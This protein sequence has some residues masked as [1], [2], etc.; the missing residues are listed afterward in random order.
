MEKW[1]KCLNVG[2]TSLLAAGLLLTGCG[3]AGGETDANAKSSAGSVGNEGSSNK[4]LPVIQVVIPNGANVDN[5]PAIQEEVN[6]ILADKTGVQINITWLGWGSYMNQTN[7]MLTGEGEADLIMLSGYSIASLAD[8]GQLYDFTDLYES[9]SEVFTK[10]VDPIYIDSGRVDGRLYTIPCNNNFSGEACVIVNRKMADELGFDLTDEEKIWTFEE[11][12]DMAAAAK[13][14]YPE[15]YGVVPQSGSTMLTAY[16]WDTLADAK[17]IGVVEDYGN[18]GKVISI[19]ECKDYINLAQ[20]MRQ[21]YTEGLIMQDVVSNTD[22]LWAYVPTGKA[23]CGFNNGGYPNGTLND[24][25]TYYTLS[26]MENCAFSSSRMSYAIAGNSRHP[27]EAFAVLKE[28]YSNPE[29]A[30]LLIWGIEGENYVLDDKQ[31]AVNPDGITTETNTYSV[32]FI[33]AWV[34][35]NMHISYAAEDKVPDFYKLL[36]KYD[37]ESLK[38]GCLGCVFDSTPVADAYAACSNVIDKYMASIMSGAVD[39]EETLAEFSKELKAA[40]EDEVI[41]AKQSQLDAFLGNQ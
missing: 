26:M 11:I 28:L 40:G 31:R 41:A 8:N 29:L 23:F 25:S 27:E 19:T 37:A 36:E 39:T 24:Q 1:K 18:T 21:W 13:E 20:T 4:E 9:D 33:N 16:T 35:P 7:L 32:G 30:N 3:A 12:H 15:V 14:K 6:K 34:M 2:V 10:A 38:S 17:N 22:S 5:T